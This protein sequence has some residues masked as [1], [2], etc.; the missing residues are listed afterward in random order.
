MMLVWPKLQ[1]SDAMLGAGG[2]HLAFVFNRRP[3][4]IAAK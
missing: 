1:V 3:Y 2:K 4:V